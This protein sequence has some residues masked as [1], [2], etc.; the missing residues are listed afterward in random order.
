MN[1]EPCSFEAQVVAAARSG[2]WTAA[3]REHAAGCASCRETLDVLPA[4]QHLA[5][6]TLAPT[7]PPLATLRLRAEFARRQELRARRD[8]IQAFV[9]AAAAAILVAVLF[10]WAGAPPQNAVRE[11]IDLA[12][13]ASSLLTGGLGLA[14]LLGFA[15]FAFV[16]MDE[17]A[18][19]GR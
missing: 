3:L 1:R 11:S 6:Q 2:S 15:M 19:R 10:W 7:P 8:P 16:L 12:T 5:T 17:P 4:M 18:G 14:V 13:S 9:P